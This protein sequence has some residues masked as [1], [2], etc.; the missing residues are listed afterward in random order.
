MSDKY[1]SI[2]G[3]LMTID[4]KLIKLPSGCIDPLS[5]NLVDTNTELVNQN[6]ALVEDIETLVG[7]ISIDPTLQE[8]TV[9]PTTEQ[10]VVT[11]DAGNDGLSKVTINAVT[12]SI[13]SNIKAENIKKDTTILGVTGTLESGGGTSTLKTLL[14]TTKSM[15]QWFS[16]NTSTT[17]NDLIP[18]NDTV[19]VEKVNNI[20]NGCSNLVEAPLFNT[21]NVI[22]AQ[23]MFNNCTKLTTVPLYDFSKLQSGCGMFY[24]CSRL[25]SIPAFDFSGMSRRVDEIRFSKMFYMCSSLE[26]IPAIKLEGNNYNAFDN[27]FY[28]CSKL[29]Y[30]HAYGMNYNF[31]ISYSTLFTE[32]ALVEILNNLAT[33]TSTQTLTMGST[34]LAKLTKED[35]RIATDKGWTLK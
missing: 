7:G 19:N 32:E 2:N 11:P 23:Y 8:K 10:Q 5:E 14:D 4:N 1:L 29:S 18:F 15:N 34:N 30:F 25:V 33:V 24:N 3:K 26:G 13:D 12:S 6:K 35:Q 22:Y 31:N 20:F 9:T 28:N 17:L 21:K 16:Y 27:T